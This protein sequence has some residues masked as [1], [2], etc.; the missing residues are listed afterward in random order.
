MDNIVTWMACITLVASGCTDSG[1]SESSSSVCVPNCRASYFCS[2]G[3]CIS[4]CNPPCDTG[5]H[6]EC[7]QGNKGSNCVCVTQQQE[8]KRAEAREEEKKTELRAEQ[9]ERKIAEHRQEQ[10]RIERELRQAS[11]GLPPIDLSF[12]A[13]LE[14]QGISPELYLDPNIYITMAH[15]LISMLRSA[16]H[17]DEADSLEQSVERINSL[18]N[19]HARYRG[20][21]RAGDL[22]S[23]TDT[24]KAQVN[25]YELLL[26]SERIRRIRRESEGTV[27][28]RTAS[29]VAGRTGSESEEKDVL[30]AG[31]QLED[32]VIS[33]AAEAQKQRREAYENFLKTR[34][35]R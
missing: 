8:E 34:R 9:L 12:K 11:P 21:N 7:D 27:S 17:G 15:K 6:C 16:D 20:K 30:G 23:A 14:A 26:E 35:A 2:E 25:D 32:K 22:L 18:R 24:L 29:P 10:Q 33:E 31:E 3:E 4:K 5:I 28:N 13:A 19:P 1:V